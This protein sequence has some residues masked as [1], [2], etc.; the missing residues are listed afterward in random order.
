VQE[1]RARVVGPLQVVHH[2]HH[3]ATACQRV[4]KLRDGAKQT[5]TTRLRKVRR[6]A[7]HGDAVGE[8]RHQRRDLGE[9]YRRQLLQRRRGSELHRLRDEV[10]HRL[11]G[12][13]ALDLVAARGEAAQPALAG[14]CRQ[15][16]HQAALADARLA[17]HQHHVAAAAREVREQPKE[18]AVL[19]R[20][21]DE[22]PR[23]LFPARRCRFERLPVQVQALDRAR[24]PGRLEEGAALLG[25][26][27]QAFGQALGQAARGPALVGFDLA[28]RE[29]RAAHVPGKRFLR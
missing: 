12:H 25:R 18:Q 29:A 14:V 21:A 5:R 22:R 27:A 4:E 24:R 13:G 9:R 8:R 17:L 20:A 10:D 11:V 3:L 19:A 1:L 15:L 23:V 28:N 16:A 2:H 6:Q 26:D 7:R